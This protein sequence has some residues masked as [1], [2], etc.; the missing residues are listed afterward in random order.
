MGILEYSDL[1]NEVWTGLP[2]AQSNT[3]KR[4]FHLRPTESGVTIVSTLPCAPMRGI[5]SITRPERLRETLVEIFENFPKVTQDEEEDAKV[6]LDALGFELRKKSPKKPL[7]EYYQAVMINDLNRGESNLAGILGRKRINFVASELIFTGSSD[8]IDVVGYE[9]EARELYFFEL[10]KDRTLHVEQVRNYVDYYSQTEQKR[11]LSELLSRYPINKV[12][13]GQFEDIK[14]VMVMRRAE[15]SKTKWDELAR[16]HN[17]GIVF[18]C[19]SLTFI[20]S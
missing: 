19:S 13:V 14:G 10:K 5:T 4:F 18:F 3:L 16:T 12:P 7:E 2:L 6:C 9:P 17:V 1:A 8:R 11:F 20:G 15:N